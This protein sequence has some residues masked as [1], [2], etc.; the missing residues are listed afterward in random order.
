MSDVVE[1]QKHIC[2]H[3]LEYAAHKRDELRGVILGNGRE[4]CRGRLVDSNERQLEH[5]RELEKGRAQQQ[6]RKGVSFDAC[7]HE[8]DVVRDDVKGV[9][10]VPDG[11]ER[12]EHLHAHSD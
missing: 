3:H 1:D 5:R 4:V 12:C 6:H 2:G 9:R 7:V 8:R 11:C 10:E